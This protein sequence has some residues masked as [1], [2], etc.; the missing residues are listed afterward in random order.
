M[1]DATSGSTIAL[2]V[3]GREGL[4]IDINHWIDFYERYSN[5]RMIVAIEDPIERVDKK[6]DLWIVDSA[7]QSGLLMFLQSDFYDLLHRHRDSSEAGHL[8]MLMSK[9]LQERVA[10]AEGG[11]NLRDG[12]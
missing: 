6:S 10:V 5:S 7:R 8:I 4:C 3:N 1:L 12:D 2:I 9:S 11:H